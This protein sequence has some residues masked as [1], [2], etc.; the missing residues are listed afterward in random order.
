M[1][2]LMNKDVEYQVVNDQMQLIVKDVQ[3]SQSITAVWLVG[4]DPV[5][6]NCKELAEIL[7]GF[8]HF[9][10]LPF[11]V[12]I[13]QLQIRKTDDKFEWNDSRCVKVVTIQCANHLKIIIVKEL[14]KTFNNIKP[15]DV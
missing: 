15:K 13:Q 1:D 3:A 6:T 4:I 12:K 7:Q 8:K 9:S 5:T 2:E 14:R 11:H 10:K